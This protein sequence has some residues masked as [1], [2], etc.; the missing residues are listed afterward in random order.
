M[1][2]PAL[3]ASS[4]RSSANPLARRLDK[5][6]SLP[7][8]DA[9]VQAALAALAD[10]F[11]NTLDARRSL[12]SEAEKREVAVAARFRDALGAVDEVRPEFP[13]SSPDLTI[14]THYDAL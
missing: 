1:D 2:P 14:P 7:L 10:D 4:A 13:L 12:R 5:A 6:L 8:D 3:P 11:S 9:G